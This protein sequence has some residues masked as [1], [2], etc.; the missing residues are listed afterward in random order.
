MGSLL[1]GLRRMQDA[2]VE[3]KTVLVRVDY[4][5]PLADGDVADDARIKASLPTLNDLIDRGAKLT[6]LT[7]LGRPEGRIISELRVDPVAERLHVLLDRPVQK[8]DDCIGEEIKKAITKG[9][10][11]DL[12]LLENLRF[13]PEETANDAEF[14][15]SLADLGDLYVNDA[16]ATLHRG[17]ASTLGVTD[18]LPAYAGKLV[19][20]ELA[21]LSPLIEEPA[22]PYV[23]IVGGKKAKSKLGALRDLLDQVD[24][25]LIGGGVAFTFLRAK[26][27]SVGNSIVDES[28][29]EEIKP[30]IQA[31]YEKNVLIL[32]PRDVVIAEEVSATAETATCRADKIPAGWI[33][34]DI[35]P[36]TIRKFQEQINAAKTIV[37]TGPMGAFELKPFSRGTLAIAEALADSEAYT[38]VGGGETGEAVAKLGWADRMSY[39]STGG[40]ACLALLRGKPLPALDALRG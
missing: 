39:V 27:H 37:W 11:G 14:A 38:V 6:L 19:Q 23:A 1:N 32:L 8:L 31:A 7:H 40:G 29:L 3:G 33:G 22:R 26:G 25:I 4:N 13:H 30:L 2:A 12:F 9:A 24:V 36:K 10:P 15:R 28:L 17:H 16:F 34:L 5:V 35:G 18:Y 20:N 21:A